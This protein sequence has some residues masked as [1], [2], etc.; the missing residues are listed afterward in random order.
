M[1]GVMPGT[2]NPPTY[3]HLEMARVA[4]EQAGLQRVDWTMSNIS[5]GKETLRHPTVAERATV[6]RSIAEDHDWLDIVVTDHQLVT[7][8]AIGYDVLILGA[9]KWAQV[10]DPRWY[11]DTTTFEAAMTSLPRCI[12]VA[13]RQGTNDPAPGRATQLDIDARYTLMSSTLAR[14][15]DPHLMLPQ[16]AASG[17]WAVDS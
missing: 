13:P 17:L 10:N 9:D 8:I 11:G 6:L 1:I 2:F 3:A 16:A 14:T 7:E 12:L 15:S 4:A 5:L